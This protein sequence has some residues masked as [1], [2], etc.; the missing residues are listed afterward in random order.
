MGVGLAGGPDP[1]KKSQ[2]AIGFLKNAG[3]DSSLKQLDLSGP[4]RISREV[5]TALCEILSCPD[6][7]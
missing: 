1:L 7:P 3:R 2:V 5:H 4:I 6:M